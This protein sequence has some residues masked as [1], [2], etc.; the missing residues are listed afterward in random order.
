LFHDVATFGLHPGI[1][2]I[3]ADS[4]LSSQLLLGTTSGM[5]IVYDAMSCPVAFDDIAPFI[6]SP[7]ATALIKDAAWS[8]R[9]R[10][11]ARWR[12]SVRKRLGRPP[13]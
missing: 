13:R 8:H 7:E 5:A 12:N 4:P 1:E 10:H 9:H 2:K 6:A 11:L 3:V